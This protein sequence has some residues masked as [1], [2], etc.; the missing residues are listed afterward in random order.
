[1]G[2]IKMKKM[3]KKGIELNFEDEKSECKSVE[4]IRK[5]FY[6]KF[7]LSIIILSLAILSFSLYMIFFL[8]LDL[9]GM[10]KNLIK[11]T[12]TNYFTLIIGWFLFAT[13]IFLIAYFLKNLLIKTTPSLIEY[14]EKESRILG[15]RFQKRFMSIFLFLLFNSIA[16]IIFILDAFNIIKFDK[17]PQGLAFKYFFFSYLGFSIVIPIFYAI[18]N[19]NIVIK[20][21]NNFEIKLEFDF[22]IKKSKKHE[23][24]LIGIK[25][26]SNKLST[27]FDRC[28]KKIYTTIAQR[29]WLPGEEKSKLN[30]YLHF[31][32]FSTPFNFQNQFLNI[33]LA[34]NEWYY[35]YIVRNLCLRH[36]PRFLDLYYR[37]RDMEF[38]K[39]LT[40]I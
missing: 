1:M 15:L 21:K 31:R 36:I 30:P 11:I 16:L 38:R 7:I 26:K 34:L 9:S 37:E 25:F 35:Y 17:P 39:F 13:T 10:F 5:E 19:D 28:G 27:K 22:P 32:C 6:R 8:K 3:E 12:H 2:N 18:F 4:I 24:Q 40:C 29:R 20:L 23:T 14:V 33:I